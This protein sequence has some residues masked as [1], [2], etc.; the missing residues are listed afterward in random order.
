MRGGSILAGVL[1]LLTLAPVVRADE[2]A[3]TFAQRCA[4]CHGQDAA[5]GLGPSIQCHRSIRDAVRT[6]RAAAKPVMPRFPD[7]SDAEIDR[8]QQYLRHLC[9]SADGQMLYAAQCARC[10]GATGDG[11]GQAPPVACATRLSEVL[12]RG[13][14]AAMPRFPGIE[15]AEVAAMQAYLAARCASRGRPI[16]LVYAANCATCHGRTGAGG[17]NALWS[18]GPDLRCT[19]HDDFVQ[20]VERGWGGMP[21]FPDL[22]R[23]TV[24]ALYRRFHGASCP[25]AP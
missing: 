20:A 6:G 5:G 7:L 13:R 16:D 4:R 3:V 8:I 2:G 17:R 10:H 11:T 25:S 1:A 22:D 9:P 15:D 14:D 12:A 21:A 19:A 24:E 23:P 18:E